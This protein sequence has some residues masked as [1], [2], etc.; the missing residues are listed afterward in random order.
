MI[1]ADQVAATIRL[2]IPGFVLL[3]V[4]YLVGQRTKRADWEWTL[5]SVLAS[6]PIGL[7][8]SSLAERL[9]ASRSDLVSS[10]ADCAANQASGKV[11]ADV[12]VAVATCAGDSLTAHNP[13]LE[14]AIALLIALAAGLVAAGTWRVVCKWSPRLQQKA[15][16]QAWDAVLRQPHWVQIKVGDLIYSGKVETVADPV[17]TETLDIYITEPAIVNAQGDV[18]ELTATKGVLLTRD[19][20]D[21]IQVLQPTAGT[22]GSNGS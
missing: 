20:I 2:L 17:E 8:A 5:W 22:S 16:L 6:V 21:W 4:F 11:A 3:K 12:K 1:T 14:L 15:S 19:K 10:I 9:G 13:G 7:I 18:M